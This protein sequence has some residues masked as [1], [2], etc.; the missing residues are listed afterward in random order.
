MS[1]EGRDWDFFYLSQPGD[2][3]E[4]GRQDTVPLKW[5]WVAGR[6]VVP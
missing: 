1:L 3:E 2:T 5:V 6:Q 4:E